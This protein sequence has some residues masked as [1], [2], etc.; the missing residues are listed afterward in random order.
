MV[1]KMLRGMSRITLRNK[2]TTAA[3]AGEGAR[4][5]VD[6]AKKTSRIV[7]RKRCVA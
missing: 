2:K 5:G 6:K 4:R 3:A 7:S 1:R